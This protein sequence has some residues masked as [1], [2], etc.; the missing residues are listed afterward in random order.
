M[1]IQKLVSLY[2]SARGNIGTERP[3]GVEA[4][5]TEPRMSG[6]RLRRR[7]EQW[8]EYFALVESSSQE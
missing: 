7:V 8:K 3:D 1:E 5:K 2:L 6:M 4:K